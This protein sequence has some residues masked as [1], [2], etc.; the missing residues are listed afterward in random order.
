MRRAVPANLQAA[1]LHNRF[2][3]VGTAK[4]NELAD[5]GYLSVEDVRAMKDLDCDHCLAA[6]VQK[7]KYPTV[8][9][10]ATH[11]NHVFYADILYM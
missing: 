6:N 7:E 9:Y 2:G 8:D 1:M 5:A 10:Q 4:L 11:P 3:H